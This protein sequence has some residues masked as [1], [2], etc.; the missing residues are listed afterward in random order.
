[1]SE[2]KKRILIIE[3]DRDILEA[4]RIILEERDFEVLALDRAESIEGHIDDFKPDLILLD[5]WVSGS[6]GRDV[7]KWL[8]KNESTKTIPLVMVSANISTPSIAKEVKADDFVLKPFDIDHL[9][10]VVEKRLKKS[11]RLTANPAS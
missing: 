3:D 7:A 5:I 10:S 8:K 2:G 11:L 4:L 6:D 1:M 9:V